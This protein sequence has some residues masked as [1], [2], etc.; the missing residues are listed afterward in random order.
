MILGVESAMDELALRLDIDPFELRRINACPRGRPAAHSSTTSPNRASSGVRTDLINAS[1]SPGRHSRRGNGV[2]AP[3][4]AQWRV[5]EGM[6]V[7][8][9]ATIAA[10][11]PRLARPPSP[12][13]PKV[14]SSPLSEP[15]SSA[16]APRPCTRR[17][18]PPTCR[19]Q[20]TGSSSAAPT[21]TPFAMTPARSRPPA[22]PWRAR[23]CTPQPSLCA[24]ACSRSPSASG[25]RPASWSTTGRASG[26]G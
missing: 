11:R 8:M 17:S 20:P 4:G 10:L 16:A 9:I 6:A 18:W 15:P 2:A 1:T 13:P 19:R 5:G 22:S 26:R 7:A 14:D 23:R 12:P 3:T 21:P 24:T 25:V